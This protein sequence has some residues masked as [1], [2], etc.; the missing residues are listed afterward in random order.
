MAVDVEEL[1][2]LDVVAVAVAVGD[3]LV[4]VADVGADAVTVTV[5]DAMGEDP[6]LP[7]MKMKATNPMITTANAAMTGA[8]ERAASGPGAPESSGG[9][10]EGVDGSKLMG[11]SLL[12]RRGAHPTARGVLA[13]PSVG[14]LPDPAG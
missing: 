7:R 14:R 4:E 3:G 9:P 8:S 13:A 1:L 6:A 5:G 2:V 11:F 12:D 10:P